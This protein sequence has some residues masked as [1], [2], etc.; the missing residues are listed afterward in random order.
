MS[1]DVK[2][3]KRFIYAG[4]DLGICSAKVVITENKTILAYEIVPYKSFPQKAAEAAI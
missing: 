1:G 2:K 4:C 3:Q